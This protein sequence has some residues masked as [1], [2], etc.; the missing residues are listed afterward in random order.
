MSLAIAGALIAL[1]I[2]FSRLHLG[3]H[4]P[5]DVLAGYSVAVPWIGS[6]GIVLLLRG[7]RTAET[8]TSVTL[9]VTAS[10]R[11]RATLDLPEQ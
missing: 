9:P 8:A 10:L 7:T 3:V 11:P 6:V 4:Y 5:P 2:G 1:L